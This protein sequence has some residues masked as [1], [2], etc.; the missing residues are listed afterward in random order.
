M[1]ESPRFSVLATAPP[2]G[3]DARKDSSDSSA[4]QDGRTVEFLFENYPVTLVNALRRTILGRI[5]Y[6]AAA[7]AAHNSTAPFVVQSNTGRLDDDMLI[8]R[9]SM[10]PIHLSPAEVDGYIP[11]SMRV[12]LRVRNETR[13]PA[14]VTSADLEVELHD[15]P[16][17]SAHMFPPCPLSGDHV[18]ITKLFPG[19]EVAM[20]WDLRK[21]TQSTHAAFQVATVAMRFVVDEAAADEAVAKISGDADLAPD[22]RRRDL[23]YART[24]GRQ[25]LFAAAPSGDPAGIILRVE[26]LAGFT[27]RAT[28]DAAVRF[29]YNKFLVDSI[30]VETEPTETRGEH[31]YR[32]LG[33]DAT[34]GSVL[35]HLAMDRADEI[36]LVAVGYSE[37]HPLKKEILVRARFADAAEDAMAGFTRMK[38]AVGRDV[39]RLMDLIKIPSV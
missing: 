34:F 1:D 2:P 26:P 10:V 38:N 12:R 17:A 30:R 21:D 28:L 14:D 15:T 27:A 24:I 11:G 19:E 9:L 31:V 5:D 13:K 35:Q 3:A 7:R 29:V 8:D 36:G 22:V 18:L 39:E 16:V 25:R 20:Y 23:N 37:T 32:I 4:P 6:V 33:E